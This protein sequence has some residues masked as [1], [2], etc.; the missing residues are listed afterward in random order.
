MKGI[1]IIFLCILSIIFSACTSKVKPWEKGI[2]AQ[3]NMQLGGGDAM[4]KKVNEHVFTSKEG[5]FG[6][7][8]IGGG[9]C[10]CN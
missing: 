5:S 3:K 6:G 7:G 4:M 2:L 9:G 8:G 1:T 10:G